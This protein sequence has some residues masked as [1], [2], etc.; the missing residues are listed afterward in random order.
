LVTTYLLFAMRSSRTQRCAES[1]VMPAT[2][3]LAFLYAVDERP[4]QV[5]QA[6][7][8]DCQSCRFMRQ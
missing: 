1:V 5:G 4:G 2:L 8:A 3:A 7:V 6:A